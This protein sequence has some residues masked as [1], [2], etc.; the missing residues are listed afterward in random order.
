MYPL[1]LIYIPLD[2]RPVNTK[3]VEELANIAQINLQSAPKGYLGKFMMRGDRV[4]LYKWLNT[5]AGDALIISLDMLLYGGLVA[6]RNADTSYEEAIIFMEKL[7]DYKKNTNIKIYAFS[8]IMRLSI[9]VFGEE[10]G[11]WW[12]QVNKYNELR[13]KIEYLGEN[14]LKEELEEII[15]A[16]PQEVLSE[17]LSARDRNHNINKMAVDFV[18]QGIIDFL[19][20]SQEDCSPYGL[21]LAEH[22]VLHKIIDDNGLNDKVSI[23]PGADEVGQMLLSKSI[24]DFKNIYPKVYIF[25]D[26]INNKSA[27]PKFEDRPLEINVQE[28]LKAIGAKITNNI[29]ECDFILA[30]TTPNIPHIDMGDMFM[31]GYNKKNIIKDFVKDLNKYIKGGNIVY[32]VDTACSNGGDPNLIEALK[33]EDILLDIAGYSAWNTAGNT[34]GTAI[35]FGSI[36]NVNLKNKEPLENFTIKSLEFLIKRYTDDYIYQSVVRNKAIKAIEEQGLSILNMEISCESINNYVFKEMEKLV[37]SYF[38]NKK[39][40]YTGSQGYIEEVKLSAYLPW[41]R[42][43]EVD[44]DVKLEI[45]EN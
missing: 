8:N 38:E 2:D 22:E 45:R 5:T 37:K 40:S 36:L 3:D 16:L 26:D 13:Y 28:H 29:R 21:H 9:S 43:F 10:S 14:Q 23:F 4:N 42:V 35:A 17:Y 39:F 19:I 30:V 6:S 27:I 11:K 1:K 20:L 41:D 12:Q 34:M 44:C 32:L 15:E 7:K 18:K 33:E 25:Y 24:N 31:K